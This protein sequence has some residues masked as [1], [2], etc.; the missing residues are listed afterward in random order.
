[1][2]IILHITW[3][4]VLAPLSVVVN[5]RFVPIEMFPLISSS[6]KKIQNGCSVTSIEMGTKSTKQQNQKEKKYMKLLFCSLSRSSANKSNMSSIERLI[7]LNL[8]WILQEPQS[9]ITGNQ[10]IC[11]PC[12]VD[13]FVCVCQVLYVNWTDFH[14]VHVQLCVRLFAL[15]ELKGDLIPVQLCH[16]FDI[17]VHYILHRRSFVQF[18]LRRWLGTHSLLSKIHWPIFLYVKW[19]SLLLLLPKR[20]LFIK[21][22]TIY[23]TSWW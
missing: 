12:F 5:L 2:Q 20:V 11:C 15:K 10:R 7:H 14:H 1:M 21:T 13:Y 18:S 22:Y 23:K 17:W 19:N 4:I 8:C 9:K 6:V 3:F 16:F